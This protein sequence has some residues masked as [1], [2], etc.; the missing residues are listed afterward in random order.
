MNM[1]VTQTWTGKGACIT[2]VPRTTETNYIRI[3][4]GASGCNSEVRIIKNSQ[5]NTF[6][7]IIITH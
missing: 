5:L 6:G 1:I 7:F 4:N 3:Y 2:F